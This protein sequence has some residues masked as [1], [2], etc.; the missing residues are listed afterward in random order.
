[1]LGLDA[2][3]GADDDF[4]ALG[5]DS[6]QLLELC[7][8]V[9]EHM[10]GRLAAGQAI[11]AR[12]L[13]GMAALLLDDAGG[14]DRATRPLLV[15]LRAGDADTTGV[16]L[17]LVPGAG[18]SLARLHH[19]AYHVAPDRRV[20]G[21]EAPGLYPGERRP[22][23]GVRGFAGAYVEALE[24]DE[25]RGPY[26]LVAESFGAIVAQEMAKRL[27]TAGHPPA[28]LVNLDGVA[29]AF[30]RRHRLAGLRR[31][32][33]IALGRTRRRRDDDALRP[34]LTRFM[35]DSRR[36]VARHRPRPTTTPMLLFTSDDHRDR[37]GDDTLGWAPLLA[38]EL[39]TVH[40]GGGHLEL[41]AAGHETA[42]L[43]DAALDAEIARFAGA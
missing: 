32:V 18:G 15:P 11:G 26:A 42:H 37:V 2:P 34:R 6:L 7:A 8:R 25:H 27:E 39:V 33:S 28:L 10:D 14:G 38:G 22:R 21:F 1:M 43:V 12:T 17:Y 41:L 9:D 16:T 36:D 31:V 29:P 24:A 35:Y 23:R 13:R 5:G 40:R 3:I 4:F 30:V 19:F 20:L